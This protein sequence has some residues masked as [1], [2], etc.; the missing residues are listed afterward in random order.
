M[1]VKAFKRGLAKA[2]GCSGLR[3]VIGISS[4]GC[5][6]T[7]ASGRAGGRALQGRAGQGRESTGNQPLPP[8]DRMHRNMHSMGSAISHA[9]NT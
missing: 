9:A 1:Y 5:N 3:H 7:Q 2:L 6:C 4:P 8:A